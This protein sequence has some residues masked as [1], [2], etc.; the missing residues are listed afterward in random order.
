MKA[1]HEKFQAIYVGK[2]ACTGID[3]FEVQGIKIKYE[4]SVTLFGINFDYINKMDKHMSE[5]CQKASK[6]LAVLKRIGRVFNKKGQMTI[7][8]S[9]I[10]PV[11][12]IAQ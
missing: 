10:V 1:Y 4:E 6:Q 2:R 12:I 9:F 7:Y 11:L 5:I 8:S 3:S